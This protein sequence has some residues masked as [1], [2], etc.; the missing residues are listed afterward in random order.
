MNNGQSECTPQLAEAIDGVIVKGRD[1]GVQLAK[2]G[3]AV[4]HAFTDSFVADMR[5]LKVLLARSWPCR[6]DRLT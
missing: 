3:G 1:L 2:V 6:F 5:S 4:P